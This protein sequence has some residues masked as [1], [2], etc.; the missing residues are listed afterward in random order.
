M[1]CVTAFFVRDSGRS[2]G[3][4][5][6]LNLR[7]RCLQALTFSLSAEPA[8]GFGTAKI[9]RRCG[10][11]EGVMRFHAE[12]L[13]CCFSRNLNVLTC[14]P[15]QDIIPAVLLTSGKAAQ[16]T[17][18]DD[19][20]AYALHQDRTRAAVIDSRK[21]SRRNRPKKRKEGFVSSFSNRTARWPELWS[22]TAQNLHCCDSQ[23]L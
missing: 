17:T 12:P 15:T 9:L 8:E 4:R 16:D 5:R 3:R 23:G 14:R 6:G 2:A 1:G 18:G 19:K 22:S 11:L 7:G 20:D 13:G 10:R 21:P